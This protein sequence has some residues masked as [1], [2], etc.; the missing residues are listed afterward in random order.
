LCQL[1]QL[2]RHWKRPL[3]KVAL[4]EIYSPLGNAWLSTLVAAVPI[5]VVHPAHDA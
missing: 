2:Q 5:N 3:V 1:G 4:T